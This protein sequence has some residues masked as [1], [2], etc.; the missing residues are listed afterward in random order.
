MQGSWVQSMVR[1]LR[2]HIPH[3]AAK[4]KNNPAEANH[5]FSWN[6][7]EGSLPVGINGHMATYFRDS[8]KKS[9]SSFHTF[10]NTHTK[11][12]ESPA[13]S[14]LHFGEPAPVSLYPSVCKQKSSLSAVVR[15]LLPADLSI[16]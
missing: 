10:T 4:K 3:G 7:E 13:Y 14:L 2:S 1:K 5:G 12:G 15:C 9:I 8:S 16:G 6:H 11:A